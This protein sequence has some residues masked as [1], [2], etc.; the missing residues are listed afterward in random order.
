MRSATLALALALLGCGG[1]TTTVATATAP[2]SLTVVAPGE[3]PVHRDA[4]CAPIMA[5]I[6]REQAIIARNRAALGRALAEANLREPSF[7]VDWFAGRGDDWEV[8]EGARRTL[9]APTTFDRCG[10]ANPHHLAVDGRDQVF[11]LTIQQRTIARHELRVCGCAA[12]VP[13]ACG[14]TAP[15]PQRWRWIL[16]TGVSYAGAL[17][18]VVDDESYERVFDGRADGTPCPPPIP[19]P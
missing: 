16:P 18:V 6:E 17:S 9:L 14:G 4:T 5:V 11:N 2:P 12:D 3:V 13:I 1:K 10:R 19:P 15:A 8:V 7:D